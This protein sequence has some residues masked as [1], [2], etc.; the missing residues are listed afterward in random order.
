MPCKNCSHNTGDPEDWDD[1][2][3]FCVKIKE[4]DVDTEIFF[5]PKNSW[6]CKNHIAINQKTHFGPYE[7]YKA[8]F[9]KNCMIRSNCA[10]GEYDEVELSWKS[11]GNDYV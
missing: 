5:E 1:F 9:C 10:S 3:M 6:E 11:I 8:S 4:D 2:C 7:Q